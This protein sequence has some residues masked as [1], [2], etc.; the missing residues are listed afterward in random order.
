[1]GKLS[2][3]LKNAIEKAELFPLAT[4]SGS[5]LPNVVPIKFHGENITE[6]ATK[7]CR[8]IEYPYP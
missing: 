6:P 1:M 7:S 4:A 3:A 5:G 2:T 8:S